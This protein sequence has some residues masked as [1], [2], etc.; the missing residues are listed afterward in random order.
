MRF[1]PA[2]FVKEMVYKTPVISLDELRLRIITAVETV[3]P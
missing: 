1:L 3:T 2:G